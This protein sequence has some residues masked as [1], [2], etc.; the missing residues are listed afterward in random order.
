MKNILLTIFLGICVLAPICQAQNAERLLL[1]ENFL[2]ESVTEGIIPGGVFQVNLKGETIF[3]KTVGYIDVEKSRA[4]QE[5]DIFR[6]ASMTKA[7]TSVAIMQLYENGQLL[8]DD[9]VSQYIPA[10]ADTKVMDEFDPT[11]STYTTKELERPISIRHLLTHTSGIY[12]GAFMQNE[13]RAIS[14]KNNAMNYGLSSPEITTEQMVNHIAT[15]P[16]VHQPG[17]RWTY[18]LNM[19][20]LGYIIEV[21]SGQSLGEYIREHITGPLGLDDTAFY[22]P[23]SKASRIVPVFMQ[24]ESETKMNSDPNLE[25]PLAE[26]THHYAGGG[27]MSSTT[28]DYMR[29]IEALQYGG[30]IDGVRILGR[31]TVEYMASQ[32][33]AHLTPDV[34]GSVRPKG[35]GFGLGF[36]VL[37]EESL[38]STPMSP[39]TYSWGGYF[40]TKFWIDPVEQLSFVGMTQIVP[41]EHGRFW[42]EL[43]AI[44]YSSLDG[45]TAT[46]SKYFA[47]ESEG[48]RNTILDYVEGIYEVDSTRIEKSVH[49]Q[50]RKRG[51]WYNADKEKYSD[52]LDMSFEQLRHLS[53]TW[54]INGKMVSENS[55][56]KIEIYDVND[57]TA[58]A[59]LT[60][61]WG[62]DYFQLAKLDGKWMIMNV[63]WQSLK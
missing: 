15:L 38:G 24:V 31:K 36:Q 54:N 23:E 40:N 8:I 44:I 6:I 33:T 20:V 42:E 49:S 47:S 10:F 5:D 43:Y 61:E 17:S 52:N 14:I 41:F 18:G 26:F 35:S 60:A 55:P 22:F 63:L 50:L 34:K 56:K 4:Y 48:V 3:R 45:D 46:K 37:T 62:I 2:E 7:F 13:F 30:S 51:Y 19:E 1:L 53:A 21:V 58:S 27:G 59:K 28:S 57:R 11:D 9:R 25:Y 29:F 12:Y 32:Q 39:G 16:L